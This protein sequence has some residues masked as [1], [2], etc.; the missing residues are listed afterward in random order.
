MREKTPLKLLWFILALVA[1][2]AFRY[3]VIELTQFIRN[4][5]FWQVSQSGW[6]D[7]FFLISLPTFGY[8]IFKRLSLGLISKIYLPLLSLAVL[9]GIEL[10]FFNKTWELTSS[11]WLNI[12][13]II[14]LILYLLIPSLYILETYFKSKKTNPTEENHKSQPFFL[15]DLKL[16]TVELDTFGYNDFAQNLADKLQIGTFSESFVVGIVGKWGSGKTSFIELLKK[17][18]NQEESIIVD[19]NP[20]Y[21]KEDFTKNLFEAIENKLGSDAREIEVLFENYYNKIVESASNNFQLP[22]PSLFQIKKENKTTIQFINEIGEKLIDEEKRLFVIVD[23]LDR[24]DKD[25]IIRVFKLIRNTLNFKNTVFITAYDR[26][27]LSNTLSEIKG[28]LGIEFSD[29]IIQMEIDLP[30]I[31]P[32]AL[33]DKL[34][35]DLIK[36]NGTSRKILEKFFEQDDTIK[37]LSTNVLTQREVNRL[38]NSFSMYFNQIDKDI[39]PKDLLLLEIIKLRFP[40]FY[41]VLFHHKD[42][43][44]KQGGSPSTFEI[45]NWDNLKLSGIPDSEETKQNLHILLQLMFEGEPFSSNSIKIPS[46]FSRYFYLTIDGDQLKKSDWLTLVKKEMPVFIREV[47]SMIKGDKNEDLGL[48][49]SKESSFDDIPNFKKIFEAKLLWSL[50]NDLNQEDLITEDILNAA[51]IFYQSDIQAL[52][53]FLFDAFT[54]YS[55]KADLLSLLKLFQKIWQGLSVQRTD[56][57]TRNQI[58][59]FQNSIVKKALEGVKNLESLKEIFGPFFKE[60]FIDNVMY[61]R[62]TSDKSSVRGRMLLPDVANEIRTEL[63]KRSPK[64]YAELFIFTDSG[65]SHVKL[66]KSLLGIFYITDNPFDPFLTGLKEYGLTTEELRELKELHDLGHAPKSL[67]AWNWNYS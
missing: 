61:G 67:K 2:L 52:S 55:E 26:T 50:S 33:L 5:I 65:D 20:W 15:E 62:I 39:C 31:K 14:P 38:V 56:I 51:K 47:E 63:I 41:T 23:D 30:T 54:A 59:S 48:F 4:S 21:S 32:K 6:L 37:K 8:F 58:T 22:L 17:H 19:F 24:L 3:Q 7:I 18:L 25:E 64:I 10:I 9:V 40:L 43:F 49:L 44:L 13:Y 42:K 46:K 35:D 53:K 34:E 29:K 1:Y 36:K 45:S 16:D 66:N 12:P 11:T 57:I 27:Y 60:L 28:G